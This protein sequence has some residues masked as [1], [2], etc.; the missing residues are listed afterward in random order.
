MRASY[1]TKIRSLNER[2]QREQRELDKD[3]S[4]LSGRKWEEVSSGAE[5]ILG[6][7]GGRKRRLSTALTKRRMTSKAGADVKESKEAIQDFQAQ[8]A[9]LE[10]ERAQ[11]LEEV[12][13]KWSEI[14][15][16]EV[17]IT[18]TPLKKDVL[19]DIFGVAWTPYYI[20]DVG[21]ES[22]EAAGYAAD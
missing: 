1:E 13:R 10:Q 8:I 2:L 14:A 18:V 15:D 19:L 20:V 9:G 3:E 7:F 21:G 11:A 22:L 4:E 6:L 17:E 5:T 16:D 12:N